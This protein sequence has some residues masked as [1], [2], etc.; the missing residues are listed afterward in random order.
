MKQMKLVLY[1]ITNKIMIKNYLKFRYTFIILA[2]I[3]LYLGL[4]NA[5]I[6]HKIYNTIN[7]QESCYQ[8]IE[9][10]RTPNNIKIL[11]IKWI[12][13]FIEEDIYVSDNEFYSHDLFEYRFVNSVKYNQI[14]N[15]TSGYPMAII[16]IILY[17]FVLYL[18]YRV[19]KENDKI[20]N[21]KI[22]N[23]IEIPF[24]IKSQLNHE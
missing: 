4:K 9:K 5:T 24:T 13:S 2:T 18:I 12:D 16:F 3:G 15:T 20:N 7:S 10:I 1:N 22:T 8:V 23:S 17:F 14:E 19:S 21:N 11:H 6:Q